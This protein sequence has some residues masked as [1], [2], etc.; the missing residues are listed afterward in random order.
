MRRLVKHVRNVGA[1]VFKRHVSFVRGLDV[2]CGF[3]GFLNRVLGGDDGVFGGVALRL[4][5]GDFLLVRGFL[6]LRFG[7]LLLQILNHFVGI[8]K[9]LFGGLHHLH[10]VRYRGGALFRRD[11]V[12]E[13][14][15]QSPG[16]R[17]FDLGVRPR[18][19]RG[20]ELRFNGR[21][22]F[23]IPRPVR[24][25]QRGRDLLHELVRGFKLL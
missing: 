9:G 20:G 10:R 2:Q 14:I 22:G 23:G 25:F 13:F 17:G 8:L 11:A 16:I 19:Q 7:D 12:R 1:R 18:L 15:H 21:D 3:C 4:G 24:V 5:G 6:V